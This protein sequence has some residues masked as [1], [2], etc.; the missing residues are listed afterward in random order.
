MR[1]HARGPVLTL[2]WG[3]GRRVVVTETED[4]GLEMGVP[5]DPENASPGWLKLE[6]PLMQN[7]PEMGVLPPVIEA[8]WAAPSQETV[9]LSLAELPDDVMSSEVA[10]EIC[11]SCEQISRV[12]D[13][14]GQGTIE[15][16]VN[17][18]TGF[19]VVSDVNTVPDM[20]GGS[21][22]VRQV[23]NP[24]LLCA[25]RFEHASL[26]V[27]SSPPGSDSRLSTELVL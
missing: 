20:S 10:Q 14:Y 25:G 6:I 13:V 18:F 26:L 9:T 8:R 22:L 3:P 11:Q 2:R 15:A 27:S 4:G 19:M 12:F 1:V 21:P 17:R 16:Y 7:G 23:R 5:E 24:G